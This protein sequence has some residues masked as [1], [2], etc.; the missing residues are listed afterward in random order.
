MSEPVTVTLEL[1]Q[2][3]NGWIVEGLGSLTRDQIKA[4]VE[5][6]SRFLSTGLPRI[7]PQN[8]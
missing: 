6:G 8:R 5:Q 4:V 1:H 3:D 2:T 7:E